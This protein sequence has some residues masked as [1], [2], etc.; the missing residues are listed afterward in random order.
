MGLARLIGPHPEESMPR[1]CLLL[2]EG[3]EEIEA[4]TLIDVL[5]RGGLDVVTVG[6]NG[7][8][9]WTA[10]PTTVV[11]GSGGIR[12]TVDASLKRATGPWDCVVMPG[13]MPCGRTL[14]E[15]AD[16]L[17]LLR[18][19]WQNGGVI[20]AIGS[21]P[22]VLGKLGLLEGKRASCYP[23]FEDELAGA[24]ISMDP[25]VVDGRLITSRGPG[26]AM[27]FALEIVKNFSGEAVA[28]DLRYRMLVP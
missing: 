8:T 17:A 1:I 28:A 2:A 6:V 14:S 3:F 19:H 21:A 10:P 15:D 24:R 9:A 13:G 4:V 22:M 5:R 7:E 20:A 16:V 26:T 27:E 18:R 23:G 12:L 25:V 11:K